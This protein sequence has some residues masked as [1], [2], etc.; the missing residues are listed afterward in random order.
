MLSLY[1]NN[2][3]TTLLIGLIDSWIDESNLWKITNTVILAKIPFEP[4]TD[5]YFLART[6]GM[7]N[8]FEEYSL[9]STIIILNTL[10]ERIRS[11]HANTTIYTL[12]ERLSTTLW[13]KEMQKELL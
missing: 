9:P 6:I 10:I 2:I 1:E 3:G 7:R 11:A 13:G 5:P 4:P 8:N 12:D